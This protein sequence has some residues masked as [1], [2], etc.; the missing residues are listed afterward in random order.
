LL[1]EP[2]TMTTILGGVL[3]LVGVSAVQRAQ[4]Q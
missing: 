1:H 2:V 3:V 4:A